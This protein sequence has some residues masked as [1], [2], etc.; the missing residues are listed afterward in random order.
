MS[1]CRKGAFFGAKGSAQEM[2]RFSLSLEDSSS[3]VKQ[4]RRRVSTVTLEDIFP[5][6][7]ARAVCLLSTFSKLQL[8]QVCVLSQGKTTQVLCRDNRF[9][10]M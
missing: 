1:F 5:E 2:K 9:M 4:K 3:A 10:N 7:L 6:V 8:A